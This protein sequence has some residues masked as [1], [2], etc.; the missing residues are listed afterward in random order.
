M[1]LPGTEFGR[2]KGPVRGKEERAERHLEGRR[3]GE[4]LGDRS[5]SSVSESHQILK[6]LPVLLSIL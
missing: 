4:G 3:G 2:L 1:K 5:I 6:P